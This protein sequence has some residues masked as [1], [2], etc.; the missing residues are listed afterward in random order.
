MTNSNQNS[1]Y[2]NKT[3]DLFNEEYLE[4]FTQEKECNFD[5]VPAI[6]NYLTYI[7][8]E[9]DKVTGQ[10]V[11]YRKRLTPAQKELYRV[12]KQK[13]GVQNKAW[14][15]QLYYAAQVGCSNKT[16]VEGKKALLQSFEQL[17]GLS[18]IEIE[19]MRTRTMHKDK[20]GK[21]INSKP[22]HMISCVDIT[23]YN[24]AHC[25]IAPKKWEDIPKMRQKIS[26]EEAEL[27]IEKMRG[28]ICGQSKI[29]AIKESRKA[30]QKNDVHNQDHNVKLHR[31]QQA[32]CS[33]L[34]DPLGRKLR[35]SVDEHINQT[36]FV[37]HPNV[38]KTDY[39]GSALK[40]AF[41]DLDLS[42]SFS[43]ESS[44]V[45]WLKMI[46]INGSTLKKMNIANNLKKLELSALYCKTMRD[47]GMNIK[48]ISGYFMDSYTKM[49][50]NN[51]Y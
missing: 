1:N 49:R 8:C 20:A 33:W 28:S 51:L 36:P 23:P 45:K 41:F 27:A 29:E 37:P 2:T 6:I 50:Y 34:N 17:E 13:A 9:I 24:N 19:H 46:G 11:W 15:S 38:N 25:V 47:K 30:A 31:A 4:K 16:V 43:S 48:N 18:L 22:I 26:K 40:L 21:Y 35:H 10:E 42:E 44:A 5:K 3:S 12:I 39:N 7:D 14:A 32:Q